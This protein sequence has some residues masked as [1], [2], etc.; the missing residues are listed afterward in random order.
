[1]SNCNCVLSK[2]YKSDKNTWESL[3]SPYHWINLKVS[4]L[5][6]SPRG[7]DPAFCHCP[8]FH[9]TFT[10]RCEWRHKSYRFP[11]KSVPSMTEFRFKIISMGYNIWLDKMKQNRTGI[12]TW[13]FFK[14][15]CI[16]FYLVWIHVSKNPNLMVL[17]EPDVS[18]SDDI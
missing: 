16:F 10:Q 15:T 6:V 2:G 11:T 17:K 5:K 18:H 4:S 3:S 8:Q 7:W 14:Y 1:M 12:N 13:I 9:S